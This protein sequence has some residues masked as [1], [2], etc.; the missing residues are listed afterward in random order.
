[1]ILYIGVIIATMLITAL[2]NAAAVGFEL[3]YLL[4]AFLNVVISVA[5]V[6]VIDAIFALAARRLIPERLLSPYSR[7]SVVTKA[8]RDLYNKLKIKSWKDYIPELGGFTSFSKSELKSTSDAEYLKRFILEINCGVLGHAAGAVFGFAVCLV[9]CFYGGV[10]LFPS[11]PSVWIPTAAVNF[12]LNILPIFIL[13]YTEYTLV[14]LCKK[15]LD[16]GIRVK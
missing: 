9:P 11:M 4:Q 12:V 3:T 6:F 2:A 7:I 15:K 1:M 14:R 16:G 5:A 10:V 13:R 8:E